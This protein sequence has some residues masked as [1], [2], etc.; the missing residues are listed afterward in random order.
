M[1]SSRTVAVP[2]LGERGG[3]V[4]KA[5]TL[6][7]NGIVAAWPDECTLVSLLTNG[8]SQPSPVDKVRFGCAMASRQLT[9]AARWILFTHLGLARVE[10][11]VLPAWR[12][13]YGIFLHGVEGWQTM[14]GRD[15]RLVRG[16]TLRLANSE[17]TV[18]RVL[19]ANPEVGDIQICPLA[20]PQGE[21][22]ADQH[23]PPLP[24]EARRSV[25]IVGRMSS[26]ER[27]KGHEELID[28]WPHVRAAVGN[29][30]LVI[31]GDGDDRPRLESRARASAAGGSIRFVGFV[32]RETLA[33]LYSEAA[34]FALPSRGEG[35]GLVYLEAMAH[36]VPCLGSPHDAAGEVIEDGRTGVLVDPG[37][38]QAL[39]GA[40]V[41]LL[42]NHGLRREMGER[43]Y[44][45]LH[46][47][48]TFE[49]FRR[50]LIGLVDRSLETAAVQ[51][52]A[53]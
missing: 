26:S 17:L 11:F 5:S 48:F 10:Q 39:G 24:V 34:I 25:L 13:P 37:N 12:A 42:R 30:E 1:K 47:R 36:R 27:Y 43:G 6:L 40:M 22:F 28:A 44:E 7:W 15:V 49:H 38:R 50:R 45:R 16:A 19:E 23:H 52:A 35:F 3:G 29:A 18:R 46:A 14:S 51:G 8:A 32:D 4:G 20:L 2:L 21:E 41:E 53:S 9:G 31:A 33:R